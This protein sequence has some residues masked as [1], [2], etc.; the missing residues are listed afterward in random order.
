N[1]AAYTGR[2]FSSGTAKVSSQPI[3]PP[4]VPGFVPTLRPKPQD[5]QAAKALM[6]QA[7]VTRAKLILDA[8]SAQAPISSTKDLLEAIAGD[9]AQIGIDARIRIL[10]AAAEGNL[11]GGGKAE[12]FLEGPGGQPDPFILFDLYFGKGSPY[13]PGQQSKYPAIG[14]A[15]AKAHATHDT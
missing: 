11:I 8:P 1:R 3:I 15:L 4:G 7:G 2:F 6:A 5:V 10:D 9:L 13:A 12:A 14:S